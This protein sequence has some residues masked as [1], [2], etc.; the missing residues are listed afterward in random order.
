M[1]PSWFLVPCLVFLRD[2]FNRLA[3]D[4]DKGADGSIGDQAHTTRTSDHNPRP[5]GAVL[6]LDIDSTG[7]WPADYDLNKAV[8]DIV[9]EHMAGRDDRLQYVIWRA[10]I[11]SRSTRWGWVPYD[12]VDKHYNHAHFSARHDRHGAMDTSYWGVCMNPA[13]I[14]KIAKASSDLTLTALNNTLRNDKSE[15]A[16]AARATPWQ[17]GAG[18]KKAGL[19]VDG[20]SMLGLMSDLHARLERIEAAVVVEP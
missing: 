10:R 16:A 18:V 13:D 2:E 3:P 4:R 20:M 7:P 5:D 11:A 9:E 8:L 12:G 17:Y 6:A 14:A 15:L 19:P 1:T